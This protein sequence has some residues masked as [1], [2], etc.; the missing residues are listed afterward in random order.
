MHATKIA[1]HLAV[2]IGERHIIG[3]DG[4]ADLLGGRRVQDA[5]QGRRQETSQTRA[6]PAWRA[7]SARC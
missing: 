7:C 4:E 6:R 2:E 1:H 5:G 3:A